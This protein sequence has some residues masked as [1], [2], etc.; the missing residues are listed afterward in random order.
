MP[1]LF[2]MIPCDSWVGPGGALARVISTRNFH[3]G[4]YSARI[5][6]SP[7]SGL[8]YTWIFKTSAD[9]D[10]VGDE[11][12]WEWVPGNAPG[13]QGLSACFA[14]VIFPL[15]IF[16]SLDGASHRHHSFS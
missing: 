13:H 15:T 2:M 12:D 6:I 11:I 7:G 1:L 9:N 10:Q 8:V 14:T 5:R 4:T 3:Y 16:P